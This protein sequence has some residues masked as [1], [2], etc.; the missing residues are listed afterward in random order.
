MIDSVRYRIRCWFRDRPFRRALRRASKELAEFSKQLPTVSEYGSVLVENRHVAH[1]P[2]VVRNHLFFT[3]PDFG[4]TI[5]CGADNEAWLRRELAGFNI[6]WVLLP[7]KIDCH[8]DF[9]RLMLSPW[10][11]E[12]VPY[13]KFLQFQHDTLLCRHGIREFVEFDWI[14]APWP[15]GTGPAW[16]GNGGLSFRDTR[17]CF[18]A[19]PQQCKGVWEDV[20]FSLELNRRGARVCSRE[21]GMKF[22][23]ESMFSLSPFGVH[24]C[25]RHLPAR[26]ASH[27]LDSVRYTPRG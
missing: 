2:V 9:S 27:L 21:E 1:L 10:F 15:E 4:L 12:Q 5:M 22:S 7:H 16:G 19:L 26:Q 6:R 13:R 24:N 11:Y 23:V 18:D 17:K 8:D 25:W 14:G 3:D 20:Y